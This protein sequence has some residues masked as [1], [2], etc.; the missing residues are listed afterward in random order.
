MRDSVEVEKV[1][2]DP[3][4]VERLMKAVEARKMPASSPDSPH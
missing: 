3:E 1:L 2:R 4:A